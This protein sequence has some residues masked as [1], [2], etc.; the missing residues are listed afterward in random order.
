MKINN[1]MFCLVSLFLCSCVSTWSA[2]DVMN[3]RQGMTSTQIQE[4]F[5]DPDDIKVTTCGTGVGKGW[6]CTIWQYGN[7]VNHHMYGTG[8]ASFTFAED[9]GVLYLNNYDIDR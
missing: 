9:Y 5:G 1:Y 3:I 6:T 7:L 4:I 2:K 8:Y